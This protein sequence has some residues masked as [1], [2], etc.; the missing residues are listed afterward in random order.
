MILAVIWP[1]RISS[2]QGFDVVSLQ[3]EFGIYG[4][5]AGTISL[6]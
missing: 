1:R 3:H 2:M 5:E 6:A 4:G